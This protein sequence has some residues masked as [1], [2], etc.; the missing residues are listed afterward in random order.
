MKKRSS[1]IKS[2]NGRL[3][4]SDAD[5][6]A[7]ALID[8][9]YGDGASGETR[10]RIVEWF[11]GEYSEEAKYRAFE[12]AMHQYLQPNEH[13]DETDAEE[14]RKLIAK[15]GLEE[16]VA[17]SSLRAKSKRRSFPLRIATR[18]AAVLVPV[19]ALAGAYLWYNGSVRP[20]QIPA[21]FTAAHH[22]AV[23]EN[24]YFQLTLGDGTGVTLNETSE[25]TYGVD[26]ECELS[27]EAY[28][29]VVKSD[30][31]F[32]V[33]AGKLKITVL[34]T[35]FNLSAYHENELSIVTLYSGSV[36]I[37][38]EHGS[39]KLEPGMEFTYNNKNH[40]ISIIH[41]DMD[42]QTDQPSWIA[43]KELFRVHTLEKIF[44][45][46]ESAYGVTIQNKDVADTA[47]LYSFRFTGSDALE[48][49]IS[50]LSDACGEFGYRID[51]KTI[52]LEKAKK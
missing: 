6:R 47:E 5:A 9:L 22:V 11:R 51:E 14:F 44:S 20:D 19:I 21:R 49:V 36:R 33:H 2:G 15:L 3:K 16:Q 50:A 24:E 39:R 8:A 29:Q 48:E 30:K 31:P 23:P 52:I 46:I 45:D 12:K 42:G 18:V 32:V 34:G 4:D 17:R 25:F 26:R 40:D 38:Y 37:D 1:I 7:V 43:D 10:N 41:I 27:G 35:E 28:F 13:P